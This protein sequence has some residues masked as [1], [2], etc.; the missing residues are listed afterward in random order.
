MH[1]V[2]ALFSEN[3]YPNPLDTDINMGKIARHIYLPLRMFYA[4]ANYEE[5]LR[6]L[7]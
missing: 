6:I 7:W 1:K 3:F 2:R 4:L 5:C